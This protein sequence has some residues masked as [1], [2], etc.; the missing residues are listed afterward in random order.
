MS[1]C[2]IEPVKTITINDCLW[3]HGT[4]KRN[5]PAIQKDGFKISFDY[6]MQYTNG[7]YLLSDRNHPRIRS[8]GDVIVKACIEGKF[9]DACSEYIWYKFYNK[10]GKISDSKKQYDEIRN[11]Y[12]DVD[13]ARIDIGNGYMLVVWN[14]GSIKSVTEIT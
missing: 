4:Y 6:Q 10:Y 13:G 7:I 9:L 8:Y 5:V 2:G 11:D 12:P 14:T 1:R 3:F